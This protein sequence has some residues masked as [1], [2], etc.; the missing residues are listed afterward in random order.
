MLPLIND[1]IH[2]WCGINKTS[3]R[4]QQNEEE[5]IIDMRGKVFTYNHF[6]IAIALK[7]SEQ[8]VMHSR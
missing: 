2:F 5:R 4:L 8:G 1:V 3:K 6:I 7:D